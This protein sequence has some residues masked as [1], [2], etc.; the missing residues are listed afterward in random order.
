MLKRYL[1]TGGK[2]PTSEFK[3]YF[4]LRLEDKHVKWSHK[5]KEIYKTNK[6]VRRGVLISK[7]VFGKLSMCLTLAIASGFVFVIWP[8]T[9]LPGQYYGKLMLIHMRSWMYSLSMI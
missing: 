1:S 2:G 5:A 4:R 8:G 9:L 3:K 7:I 6:T